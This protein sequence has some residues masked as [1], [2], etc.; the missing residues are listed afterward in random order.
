MNKLANSM[1][2]TLAAEIKTDL[3]RRQ[4][5]R[6]EWIA[7]T[8]DLCRHLAEARGQFKADQEFSQWLVSNGFTEAVL[9]RD[10]RAAAIAM[11]KDLKAAEQIL[12]DTERR[13]LQH[14]YRKEFRVRYVTKPTKPRKPPKPRIPPEVEATIVAALKAGKTKDEAGAAAGVSSTVVRRVAAAEEAR[15]QVIDADPVLDPAAFLSLSNQ[16]KLAAFERRLTRQNDAK[17]NVLVQIQVRQALD[18]IFLPAHREKLAQAERI[19]QS[20]KHLLSK[21]DFNLIR[22]CLHPDNSASK[23]RRDRAFD[24]FNKLE[25]LL[26]GEKELPLGGGAP[27]LPSSLA[28]WDEMKAKA[29][30]ARAAKRAGSTNT[31]RAR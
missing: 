22:A 31:A 25:D 24:I 12:A 30:A 28:E 27:P 18:E 13:S 5:G 21:A 26:V 10:D 14:I 6:E 8:L 23:D 19:I 1:L 2:D 11:G 16:Q 3:E 4:Q 9:S 17:V 15:Q 7:G 20:R 29:T